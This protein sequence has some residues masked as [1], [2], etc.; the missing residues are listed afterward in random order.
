MGK[1]DVIRFFKNLQWFEPRP[2]KRTRVVL[3]H[4][5]AFGGQKCYFVFSLAVTIRSNGIILTAHFKRALPDEVLP[6]KQYKIIA[7][8]TTDLRY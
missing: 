6:R 1:L 7:K 4:Y 5:T 2:S 8:S 3:D